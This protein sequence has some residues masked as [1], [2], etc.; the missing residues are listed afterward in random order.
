[1]SEKEMA[2]RVLADVLDRMQIGDDAQSGPRV[3]SAKRARSSQAAPARAPTVKLAHD[4]RER[5][6][7]RRRAFSAK[8][9]GSLE[10]P[11]DF[12]MLVD[13][14]L[15]AVDY[16]D[17]VFAYAARRELSDGIVPGPAAPLPGEL[18]ALRADMLTLSADYNDF[19]MTHADEMLNEIDLSADDASFD[20][21]PAD[22]S[23]MTVISLAETAALAL[24]NYLEYDS[25]TALSFPSVRRQ[26]LA[27]T[28]KPVSAYGPSDL[29]RALDALCNAWQR[30][31]VDHDVF[32]YVHALRLRFGVMVR[33]AVTNARSPADLKLLT[34]PATLGDGSEAR[35]PTI[36]LRQEM[37]HRFRVLADAAWIYKRHPI[38]TR[39]DLSAALAERSRGE[40]SADDV[41]RDPERGALEVMTMLRD[42]A[43]AVSG[44]GAVSELYRSVYMEYMV[45]PGDDGTF[46]TRNP[47][48]TASTKNVVKATRGSRYFSAA[49]ARSVLEVH[50]VLRAARERAGRAGAVAGCAS[51]INT[52]SSAFVDEEI[53]AVCAFHSLMKGWYNIAWRERFTVSR[54]TYRTAE[55]LGLLTRKALPVLIVAT[56]TYDVFYGGKILRTSS[57]FESIAWWLEILRVAHRS[58]LP[59]GVATF[60]GILA[61]KR[62]REKAGDEEALTGCEREE[63][64]ERAEEEVEDEEGDDDVQMLLGA[65]DQEEKID[66][67]K[68]LSKEMRR[69]AT[70]LDLKDLCSVPTAGAK[71]LKIS[72][73]RKQLCVTLNNKTVSFC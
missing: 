65:D 61:A 49:S 50:D 5:A 20:R 28:A 8:L 64:D 71:M 48:A 4:A 70:R 46:R 29:V 52:R 45:G 63:E 31:R 26:L 54:G 13:A 55:E 69:K 3:P 57:L 24:G 53:A 36:E 25:A 73:E 16:A 23:V 22:V 14:A 7:L 37:T 56:N 35:L 68:T 30:I 47:N 66:R 18:D 38:W 15:A 12:G 51:T 1:M 42:Y 41:M 32:E 19:W 21:V 62:E 2:H 17:S 40:F 39:A 72:S 59:A 67:L 27:Q 6:A 43:V 9:P 44:F 10:E 33:C 60:K 11:T 34:E 58:E